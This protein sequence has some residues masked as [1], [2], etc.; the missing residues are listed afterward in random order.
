MDSR[1]TRPSAEP[2]RGSEARSG[3]GIRPMTLR[4]R[5]QNPG[6]IAQ[7]SVGIVEIAEHDAVF[8]FELIEDAVIG[9]VAALPV[10]H[11]EAQDLARCGGGG[12]RGIGSLARAR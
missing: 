12:E 7:R 4:L 2:S 6:D 9:E 5:A 1:I 3:C 11:G 8:G 10:S